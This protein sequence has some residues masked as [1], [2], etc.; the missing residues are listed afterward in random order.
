MMANKPEGVG[1]DWVRFYEELADKIAPFRDRQHELL[2]FLGE[3]KA[4][5]LT[6]TPLED[7]DSSGASFPLSEIDPFTFFGVFN[8]GI[9][10]ETRIQILEAMKSRFQVN[11]SVPTEFSGIPVLS[12]LNSWFFAYQ[13]KRQPGDI[14]KLWDVF[15]SAIGPAP[16]DDPEFGKVF[17]AALTVRN[18]NFNLTT[19]LFWIRPHRFVSLDSNMRKRLGV[20]LPPGG[21]DFRFYRKVVEGV[22]AEWGDDVPKLSHEAWLSGRSEGPQAPQAVAE[23]QAISN[24][25]DYWLVGAYWHDSEPADQTTRMVS[26]GVWENGYEDQLLDVVKSMKVGDRIAIKATATQKKELPFDSGGRTVSLLIIKATGT[27]VANPRTGRVVEVEWDPPP[28]EPR[29]WYFYSGR[30]TV[31]RLRKEIDYAQR[32][33][34][35]VFFGEPQDYGYFLSKWYG[36]G[37]PP[38]TAISDVPPGGSPYSI[39]DMLEQGVFLLESQIETALRRLQSKKNL[40]LQGAPGVG[41][42]FIA[43]KLAYAFME[44]EDD[45]RILMSQF[46][47]SFSYEDFI[48]GY[49]PAG[50]AGKFALVDGPFMQLCQRAEADMDREYVFVLDEI[51]RGNLSQVF[52]ELFMLLEADKRGKR[53]AVTPLYRRTADEQFH[54]PEN[55]YIIGTMNIADRSL[56]L[57]DFALRRRFAYLTLEPQFDKPIFRTW[58]RDR[59]MPDALVSKIVTRMTALNEAIAADTQLGSSFR[60]GHSFFC[61]AGKDFSGL[62]E[63]WYGDIVET[64]IIPLIEEYWHDAPAKAQKARQDLLG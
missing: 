42:T 43:K 9:I 23:P 8:R 38:P 61:P 12:N 49:R 20:K 14:A 44:E 4:Q 17:D 27:I 53:N 28:A 1:Y 18:T 35:F 39:A 33:I 30:S 47:P 32:L 5:Q 59:G 50:E 21:L 7:K 36:E 45:S 16:L 31:W 34:R 57:V 40:I 58:V 2:A 37:A 56:A 52:G 60:I 6:I 54:V 51:N 22:R 11:T 55:I 29:N 13:A 25:V 26:E 48:R 3:L 15:V 64:E 24:D 41:K 10:A 19:A 46:H 63:R 62:D